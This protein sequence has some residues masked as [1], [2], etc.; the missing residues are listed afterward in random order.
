MYSCISVCHLTHYNQDYHLGSLSFI[1]SFLLSISLGNLLPLEIICPT[2]TDK[3]K[4]NH[5]GGREM[6][7]KLNMKTAG[8][9]SRVATLESGSV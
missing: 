3:K 5:T 7:L 9:G 6:R 1:L 4:K 8:V 2:V